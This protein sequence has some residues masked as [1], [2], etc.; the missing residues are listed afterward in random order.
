[1]TLAL[2]YDLITYP[3]TRLD[4]SLFLDG[5]VCSLVKYLSPKILLPSSIPFV[6]L[7][8]AH[9]SHSFLFLLPPY[10]SMWKVWTLV[11]GLSCHSFFF[12]FFC[13]TSNVPFCVF[14]F[15]PC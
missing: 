10:E 5:G 7:F 15:F 9:T 1:M 3:S 8:E 14:F 2:L 12:F 13:N 6:F 4:R 11:L